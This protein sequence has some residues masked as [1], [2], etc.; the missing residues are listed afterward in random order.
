VC[1]AVTTTLLALL[2]LG[3]GLVA[4]ST[5]VLAMLKTLLIAAAPAG[6]GSLIGHLITRCFAGA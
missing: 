3:R 1:I 4:H 2:G 6:A 5:V